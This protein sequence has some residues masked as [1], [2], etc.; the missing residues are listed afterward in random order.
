MA[1]R[2]FGIMGGTFDPIHFGHLLIA[3][4]V[5]HKYCLEKIIFIPAGNPPH[6]KGPKAS[7]RDRY[8]MANFATLTNDKF[9]VSDIEIIK[10]EKSYT[11]NTLRE[12]INIYEDTDFYFITG[13]DAII[14]LPD[15]HEADNLLK[16]CKIIAVP[17]P[18]FNISEIEKTL[19]MINENNEGNVELLEVPML[20]ISSTDIRDRI[21]NKRSV[22]YLLPEMVEQYIIKNN[23]YAENN[24]W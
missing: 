20:Q 13:A 2:S 3:N 9:T 21:K 1:K 11:I 15:W 23:L 17:R 5:L 4:E 7:S 22:K 6:K 14:T 10:E 8:I 12:L 16:L 19:K 24:S 18:G